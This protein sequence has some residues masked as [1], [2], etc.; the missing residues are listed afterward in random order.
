M[1]MKNKGGNTVLHEALLL[2]VE[3]KKSVD[4]I[5]AVARYLVTEDPELGS[6]LS[7]ERYYKKISL[8]SGG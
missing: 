3:P 8:V 4:T 6:V 5:V 1:K 2:L 7:S